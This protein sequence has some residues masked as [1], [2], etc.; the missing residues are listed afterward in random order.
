MKK[1][2]YNETFD[3]Q[4]MSRHLTILDFLHALKKILNTFQFCLNIFICKAFNIYCKYM[5]LRL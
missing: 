5:L 1:A 2:N 4:H 3:I